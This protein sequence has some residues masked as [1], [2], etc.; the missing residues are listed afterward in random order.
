MR[1][2]DG[3]G[4]CPVAPIGE[5]RELGLR[6]A[7]DDVRAAPDRRSTVDAPPVPPDRG[8]D[9]PER[10]AG[11]DRRKVRTRA[12]QVDDDIS[13]VRADPDL[14]GI[15]HGAREVGCGAADVQEERGQLRRLPRIDH[16]Q[17]A[18]DNV[19]SRERAPVGE[20]EPVTKVE[21]DLP[22]V[23]GYVP[24]LGQ[25]RPERQR[26]VEGRQRLVQLGTEGGRA[27][28]ALVRRVERARHAEEE[29]DL[30][31]AGGNRR[32]GPVA[33]RPA[34]AGHD[35]RQREDRDPPGGRA[36]QGSHQAR[37]RRVTPASASATGRSIGTGIRGRAVHW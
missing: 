4:A 21:H 33:A 13:T 9:D 30:V 23:A 35:G 1:G 27:D 26:R 25:R 10:G 2:A 31:T 15:R 17:P 16:P 14:G 36:D 5:E 34:D 8:R 12:L 29:A 37:V 6:D 32:S 3:R 7:L 28:V 22:A 20:G 11:D 24:R 19:V 18:A